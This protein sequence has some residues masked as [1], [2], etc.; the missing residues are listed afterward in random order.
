[1]FICTV[2][3]VMGFLTIRDT[4]KKNT[5][6][7]N[8]EQTEEWK[9][10]MQIGFVLYHYFAA[11]ET[12]NII[13][14]FIAAYVW[15]TGF[16]NF[17]YFWI[18]K[19]YS[20]VRLIKMLIRLN[21]LVFFVCVVMDKDYML[22]Y[23]CPLHTFYFMTVYVTMAI[24]PEKNYEPFWMRVKFGLLFLFLF[25]LFEI[26]GIFEIFWRPLHFILKYEDSLHEWEFRAGLDHYC[27]LL[28]M[29]YAY[30]YPAI[31]AWLKKVES[32]PAKQEMAIKSIITGVSL[33]IFIGWT[34]ICVPMNKYSYNSIHPYVSVI[35]YTAYIILR[36]ISLKSR[37]WVMGLFQWSGRITLETYIAQFHLWLVNDAKGRLVYI[38][39]YPLMNFVI[40][41]SVYLLVSSL[42][43][44][45][46]VILN[47]ALIPQ[48]TNSHNASKRLSFFVIVWVSLY[49][50]IALT[51]LI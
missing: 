51:R 9:G 25:I 36:N 26:P 28:G 23:V 16:G 24:Y 3:A 40:A 33:A 17:S 12:Y 34:I 45:T 8:R 29:L 37:G 43:F 32:Y 15:M 46:T 30:N 39:G 50:L 6:I 4:H 18:R 44:D 5:S 1:M 11:K 38:D 49:S 47:D 21:W 10:Y 22:Y 41:T 48:G 31:E 14:V 2:I 35:P 13:R 20:F 7:L 19:D 42:L 27:A